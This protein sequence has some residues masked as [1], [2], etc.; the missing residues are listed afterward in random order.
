MRR[1]DVSE[2]WHR[3]QTVV[4]ES[5]LQVLR[6]G[7]GQVHVLQDII[8]CQRVASGN[9]RRSPRDRDGRNPFL[10]ELDYCFMRDAHLRGILKEGSILGCSQHHAVA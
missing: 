4:S 2:T 10:L 9:P 6:L 1:G 3:M 5:S 7:L 8:G